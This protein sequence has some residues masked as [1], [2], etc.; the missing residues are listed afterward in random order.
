MLTYREVKRL[1]SSQDALPLTEAFFYILVAL[2][3]T[4]AHGYAIMQSVEQMSHGRVSIGAGTLYTA[5][6]TLLKKGWIANAATPDDMDS[7][8]KMYLITEQG[9][10]VLAAEI[11]RLEELLQNGR[12]VI[13]RA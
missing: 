1:G 7:R 9:K 13:D 5:L 6:N 2:F 11:Q 4:S 8:R 3:N 10:E 12:H